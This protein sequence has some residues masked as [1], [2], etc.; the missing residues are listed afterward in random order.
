M[1]RQKTFGN[2]GR[3]ALWLSPVV[4]VVVTFFAAI[5]WL[6]EQDDTLVLTLT[7]VLAAS[8]IGYGMF[9]SQRIQ[10]HM[11][12]VQ[13]ASQGY[14]SSRAAGWGAGAAGLVLLL[15]PVTNRLIDLAT[16]LSSSA[17]SAPDRGAVHVALALGV[18]LC[19]L[20]QVMANI[21]ASMIW[22]RRMGQT[23]EPS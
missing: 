1:V 15:P 10:G 23:Q 21:V 16:T 14:A 4:L 13:I 6:K 17:S 3:A 19:V 5:P 20:L 2:A 9:L 8:V 18:V 22:Q 7:G 11:D 12:E